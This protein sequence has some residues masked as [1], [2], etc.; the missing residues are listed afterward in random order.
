MEL[1]MSLDFKFG[2]NPK[3]SQNEISGLTK[4]ITI[5]PAGN[6]N[7]MVL[8]PKVY[9]IQNFHFSIPPLA[10]SIITSAQVS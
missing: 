5:A 2:H 8:H 3:Q 10:V 1:G 7:L 6:V 4:V 9:R